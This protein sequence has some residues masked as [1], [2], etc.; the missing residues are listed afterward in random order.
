[1]TSEQQYASFGESYIELVNKLDEGILINSSIAKV[2]KSKHS[3]NQQ[4][5][6]LGS[7]CPNC[8]LEILLFL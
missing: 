2:L 7:M 5:D 8:E 1:M 4:R 3:L 6:C